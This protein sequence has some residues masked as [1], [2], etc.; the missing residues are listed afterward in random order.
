MIDEISL[1][2]A[3]NE[4][5]VF[6]Y[7]GGTIF[8]YGLKPKENKYESPH[9]TCHSCTVRGK[10]RVQPKHRRH[11]KGHAHSGRIEESDTPVSIESMAQKIKG[12]R[13]F[14]DAK[15]KLNLSGPEVAAEYLLVSQF[16]LFADC[17]YGNRPSFDKAAA[18][19]RA[20]EYF[21]HFVKTMTRLMGE[22]FVKYT[23][24]GSDLAVELVNDGPVTLWL[25][26]NDLK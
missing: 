10:K 18:K 16:T 9:P 21:E 4:N 23:P 17:K 13:V 5:V 25:D 6:F 19:P 12:L 20:K 24:F 3:K 11:R 7:G 1:R 15:G 14:S 8:V 2:V 22:G 26:S